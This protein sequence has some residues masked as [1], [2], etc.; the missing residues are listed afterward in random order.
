[1]Y[2]H[3]CIYEQKSRMHISMHVSF[4]TTLNVKQP[5][6]HA[7][8]VFTSISLLAF[9]PLSIFACPF[10][11]PFVYPIVRLFRYLLE[12]VMDQRKLQTHTHTSICRLTHVN[13]FFI[14]FSYVLSYAN[15][16]NIKLM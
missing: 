4:S 15:K 2:I 13:M 9:I 1:M 14:K 7:T 11:S 10:H 8:F 3:I 5:T 12:Q 6:N 16:P